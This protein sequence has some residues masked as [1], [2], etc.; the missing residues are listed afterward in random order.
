MI[1]L[2]K[3][4]ISN[5]YLE[6]NPFSEMKWEMGYLWNLD[7]IRHQVR[8]ESNGR[9]MKLLFMSPRFLSLLKVIVVFVRLV[10]E[11]CRI[12]QSKHEQSIA[13]PLLRESN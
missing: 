9:V 2:F 5:L 6:F 13:D 11:F 1:W 7:S 4:L 10:V 12:W 3:N 8:F